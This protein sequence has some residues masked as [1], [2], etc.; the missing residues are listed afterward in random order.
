MIATKYTKNVMVDFW[1]WG[2]APGPKCELINA[3]STIFG[4]GDYR[5]GERRFPTETQRA[6][7]ILAAKNAKNTK[8]D[9]G[10]TTDVS[11]IVSVGV[12]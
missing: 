4:A 1:S 10:I 7:K 2:F 8:V 12:V 9:F 5:V 3:D 11:V 6:L